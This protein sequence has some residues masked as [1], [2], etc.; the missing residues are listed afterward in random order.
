MA[1]PAPQFEPDDLDNLPSEG[2]HVAVIERA[3]FHTSQQ[4]NM[5]LQ[6]VCRITDAA[7][8]SDTAFDYFVLSGSSERA[9]AVSR[10]RLLE[11]YR[12][13]GLSPRA[14]DLIRPNDLTGC[15]L[16]VRVRH[17]TYEGRQCLRVL[18]YRLHP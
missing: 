9:R 14:G 4:G 17:E 13:C 8:G 12:G 2:Y 3:R 18:G 15:T 16:E 10:R 1:D 6:V 7:A 5:T 11:L